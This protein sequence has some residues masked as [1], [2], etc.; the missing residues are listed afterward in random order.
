MY[1][2]FLSTKIYARTGITKRPLFIPLKWNIKDDLEKCTRWMLFQW[3]K[4][5]NIICYIYVKRSQVFLFVSLFTLYFI[6]LFNF[7]DAIISKI[8][9]FSR[10]EVRLFSKCVVDYRFISSCQYIRWFNHIPSHVNFLFFLLCVIFINIELFIFIS[11]TLC[12][13]LWVD[14]GCY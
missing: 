6:A 14:D 10:S 12:F 11:E 2:I 4:Q 1:N 8:R 13:S 9:V 7:P 5:N 3:H